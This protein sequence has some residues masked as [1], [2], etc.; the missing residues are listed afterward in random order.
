M[1]TLDKVS[2]PLKLLVARATTKF[3]AGELWVGLH[4]A[5]VGHQTCC[6]LYGRHGHRCHGF[7]FVAISDGEFVGPHGRHIRGACLRE[8]ITCG[9]A[10]LLRGCC[11]ATIFFRYMYPGNGRLLY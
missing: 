6:P 9:P 1:D 10:L 7:G 11:S 4:R 5:L 2:I 8:H 3:H